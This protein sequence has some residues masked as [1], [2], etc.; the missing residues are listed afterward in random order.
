MLD[1]AGADFTPELERLETQEKQS[2]AITAA[3]RRE[4]IHRYLVPEALFSVGSLSPDSIESER[5][6]PHPADLATWEAVGIHLT[7]YHEKIKQQRMGEVYYYSGEPYFPQTPERTVQFFRNLAYRMGRT[8]RYVEE[9]KERLQ[10]LERPST[11]EPFKVPLDLSTD[12]KK[13]RPADSSDTNPDTT[14]PVVEKWWQPVSAKTYDLAVNTWITTIKEGSGE[15]ALMPPDVNEV[16]AMADPDS[17]SQ[18]P[19]KGD[20]DPFTVIREGII[21]DCFRNRPTMYPGRLIGFK[22]EDD[23]EYQGYGRPNLFV[24]ATKDQRRYQAQHTRRHFFNMQRWPSSRILPHRLKA[25]RDRKDEIL[26]V[27]PSNPDQAYGVL[28][29]R[30][31]I[32]REKPLYAH[33]IVDHHHGP[34]IDNWHAFDDYPLPETTK[35][36]QTKTTQSPISP[37]DSLFGDGEVAGSSALSSNSSSSGDS[38]SLSAIIKSVGK[39]GSSNSKN[40]ISINT[41]KIETNPV[42]INPFSV[43]LFK[44]TTSGN[45]SNGT[46]SNMK[47]TGKKGK[48]GQTGV[49][50]P[51]RPQATK[52]FIPFRRSDERFAP[53]PAIFPMGDTLLQRV[54]ISEELNSGKCRNQLRSLT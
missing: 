2:T 5:D 49:S 26:R 50:R 35:P 17:S 33:P 8:M 41:V 9:I 12:L 37:L 29:S 53:G 19:L 1:H 34:N 54:M 4:F 15:I 3:K 44:T 14:P 25:I 39:T 40:V 13:P 7:R 27:D 23:K 42:N 21:D 38:E 36:T 48:M 30:L 43:N 11:T 10:V 45:N 47:S 51:K 32:G 28:T 24:W 31:P 6:S 18:N 52:G 20:Q 16:L 22:D 46:S